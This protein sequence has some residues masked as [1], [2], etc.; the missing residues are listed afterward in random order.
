MLE[1]IKSTEKKL[2]AMERQSEESFL[3]MYKSQMSE[4]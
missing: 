2:S 1:L 4:L 3:N